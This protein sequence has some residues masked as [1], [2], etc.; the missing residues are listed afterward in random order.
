MR[1]V[2]AIVGG[3]LIFG[4]TFLLSALMVALLPPIFRTTFHIGFFHTNNLLGLLLASAAATLSFPATLR[5]ARASDERKSRQSGA[6]DAK[7]GV[8]GAE[9]FS[10]PFA[11][12][13]V[14]RYHA[15]E[16]EEGSRIIVC[17][18]EPDPNLGEIVHIHVTGLRFRNRR[19]PG[20]FSDQIGHMPYAA[21]ALRKSVLAM[22][23]GEA[24][25]PMFED[26]Y[27][28]WRSEFEV[29]KAGIWTAPVPEAIFR[30][31]M[32]MNR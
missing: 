31:E 2:T 16:G 25:L 7:K 27:R 3:V 6:G 19:A 30:V 18:V 8:V 4:F 26:G 14:W 22:E 11:A 9:T 10:Q 5:R 32:V 17:R 21:D 23:P 24:E 15:R 20:G 13:Q 29:G 28:S 1:Y 12:R